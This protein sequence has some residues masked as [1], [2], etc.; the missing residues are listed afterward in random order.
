LPGPSLND[1]Q[2][3]NPVSAAAVVLIAVLAVLL[4]SNVFTVY[5]SSP[6]PGPWHVPPAAPGAPPYASGA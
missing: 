1:A 6:V 2:V 4:F 3:D 5:R